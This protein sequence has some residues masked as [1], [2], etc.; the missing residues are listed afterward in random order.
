[1]KKYT[2][3]V[4]C[5]VDLKKIEEN[6]SAI[7]VSLPA[8]TRLCAVVKADAYGHGAKAV[9]Q[10][11]KD[12]VFAFAVATAQ[13]AMELREAGIGNPILILGYVWPEDYRE[14]IQN[15]IRI[16]IFKEEDAKRLAAAAKAEGKD[17]LVHIKVDTGMNRIGF[18]PVD[19]AAEAVR[20]ICRM[21]GICVEGIFTHFARADESD[22]AYTRI[23]LSRF[24][25]FI[26]MVERDGIRIPIHHCA[27]S[28]AS[29]ELP[30][31][32]MDMVRL[33]IAMYGLYPSDEVSR[34]ITLQPAMSVVSTVVYIKDV[35]AGDGISYNH[36]HVL[37][38][39]RKV[40]TIPV[41]YGDGYPR[42]LSDRGY[43]LI[44]GKR[45]PILG[46]VCMDQLMADVTDIPDAAEGDQVVLVGNSGDA[47]IK[48]EDLSSICGVFN[49]EFVCRLSPRIPR[50]HI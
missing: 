34:K 19:E 50:I 12:K 29:M 8:G 47:S 1:M 43:V 41:G 40:A 7:A 16:P 9:A 10:H 2:N 18:K 28:A 45:A 33:G 31:A 39:P 30:E 15:E 32:A 20:R 3:R 37:D 5:I 24:K 25:A 35:P 23:Q 42:L 21:D 26:A 27:N 17:A 13:E 48:V 4:E 44:R 36:T 49:Y 14:L 22:K 46:R 11:L 6:I 38:A